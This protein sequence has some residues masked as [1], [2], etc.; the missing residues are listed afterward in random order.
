MCRNWLHLL[1]AHWKPQSPHLAQAWYT[2]IPVRPLGSVEFK[3]PRRFPLCRTLGLTVDL[4]WVGTELG[5]PAVPV[6]V[7]QDGSRFL[8]IAGSV[9][10]QHD[11]NGKRV[12]R[13]FCCPISKTEWL[14]NNM[15]SVIWSHFLGW[16][17]QAPLH[18]HRHRHTDTQA[19]KTQNNPE[20][21]W[22]QKFYEQKQWYQIL[23]K[24]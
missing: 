9:F 21:F 24:C 18:L 10:I 20:N 2:N 6:L 22:G 17:L 14:V 1:G 16:F 13:E 11:S 12:R 4:T 7:L 19:S 5:T 8:T 3:K 15:P 23:S